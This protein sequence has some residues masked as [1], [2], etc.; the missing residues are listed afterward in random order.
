LS[1]LLG[2]DIGTTATKALLLDPDRG[3]VAEAERPSRLISRQPGWAE[4]DPEAWWTNVCELTRELARGVDI[5]GVGITGMVPCTILLDGHDR[6]LGWSVQQ[7]D[8]RT[9]VEVD[10]LRRRLADAHVLQRTG[11]AVTQQA[12]GPRF[13]WFAK[14]EPDSWRQARTVLG[15]YDYI[16]LR[17]TG[18]RQVEANW[19]LETG[20]FDFVAGSWAEDVVAASGGRLDMLPQIRRPDEI[21]GRITTDAA[22]ETG[23]PAGTPVVAGAADHV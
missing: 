17:L 14:H 18:E 2:I 8:A 21:V 5:A 15:S 1:L 10:E 13:L 22:R 3:P 19:A 9:G 7:N 11:S 12:T 6:P 23:L 16:T 4:E 20:L